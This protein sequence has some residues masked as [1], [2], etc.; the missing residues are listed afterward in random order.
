MK[1]ALQ[2]KPTLPQRVERLESS[3]QAMD[4]KVN[5]VVD[6]VAEHDVRLRDVQA[7][8]RHYSALATSLTQHLTTNQKRQNLLFQG[9]GFFVVGLLLWIV[10]RVA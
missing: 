10:S 5:V 3:M 4:E 2:T 7:E 9:L 6:A 1:N 8:V